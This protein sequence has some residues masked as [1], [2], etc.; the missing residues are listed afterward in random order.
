M[1]KE[2][3]AAACV[4]AAAV[5]L[6]VIAAGLSPAGWAKDSVP[7]TIPSL[8]PAKLKIPSLDATI[9]ATAERTPGE[10][11]I[12]FL[13]CE[14][15]SGNEGEEIPLVVQVM[16]NSLRSMVSRSSVSLAPKEI[17]KTTC[18]LIID[19]EGYGETFVELP[20]KWTLDDKTT[21]KKVKSLTRYYLVVSRASKDAASEQ[22]VIVEV[23]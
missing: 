1:K 10:K 2:D 21:E 12:V 9:K 6:G 7:V 22:L 17:A 15:N 16:S 3:W 4:L 23:K 13:T 19:P 5:A 8:P 20:I 14:S 18:T 11:V